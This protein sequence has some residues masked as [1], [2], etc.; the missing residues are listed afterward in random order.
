M[1]TIKFEQVDALFGKQSANRTRLTINERR[2]KKEA[3]RLLK[4]LRNNSTKRYQVI[5]LMQDLG[6]IVDT[7]GLSRTEV[8]DELEELLCIYQQSREVVKHY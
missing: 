1:E 5:T 6:V 3:G 7:N 2:F 4:Y 8:I